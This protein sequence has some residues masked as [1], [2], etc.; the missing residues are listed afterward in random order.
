ME[1]GRGEIRIHAF[2]FVH[3]DENAPAHAPQLLADR[4]VLGGETF[5]CVGDQQDRVGL[6]DRGPRLLRHFHEYALPF[7][8]QPAGIDH[9]VR[10]VPH[11]PRAVVAIAGQAGHIGDQGVARAREPVEQ[12]GL[13]DVRPADDDE[14]GLHEKPAYFVLSAYKLPSRVC[15][16]NP[17][18]RLTRGD[19]IGLPSV[20]TRPT[21]APLSRDRK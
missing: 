18:P 19:L 2:G 9:E 5:A 7:R 17:S 12:R 10:P 6:R 8:L 1:L 16:R 11:A 13:A 21:K 20:A 14:S 15:T 4:A 3:G